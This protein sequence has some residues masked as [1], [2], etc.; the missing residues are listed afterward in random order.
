MT[1]KDFHLSDILSV[2][3]GIA[4]SCSGSSPVDGVYKILD[5][6]LG[7]STFT[8][9][10]P[11]MCEVA[12]PLLLA[13]HPSLVSVDASSVNKD[14]WRAWLDEQ[15]AKYGEYLPVP[16]MVGDERFDGPYAG[17]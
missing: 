11:G 1:T 13:A 7:R 3:T 5:A 10:I 12:K 17:C 9:E 15:I 2:T 14:N 8:H 6:V 16:V 4:L